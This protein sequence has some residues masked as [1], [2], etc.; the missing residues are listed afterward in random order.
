MK[1]PM[2]EK[3]IKIR[4]AEPSDYH[5]IISVVPGWWD[6]RDLTAMLPELFFDHFCDTSFVVEQGT[7]LIGFLVGFMSQAR[8]Q[9]A[10][11][12]FVGVH[13]DYRKKGI[14]ATLYENFFEICRKR[15]RTIVRSITSPVNTGSIAFH[16]SMGFQVE[17]GDKEISFTKHLEE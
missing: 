5:R 8:L 4:N 13:P 11:I 16:T 1:D 6:G 3:D 12:H 9:E 2:I 10:Y 7:E 15:G 17:R 14:G